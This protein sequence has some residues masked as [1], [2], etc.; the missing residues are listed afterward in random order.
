L[1]PILFNLHREYLTKKDPEVYGDFR[2]GREVIRTVKCEDDLVLLAKDGTV[3]RGMTDRVV[4]SGKMLWKENECRN[5][6]VMRISGQP[7]PIQITKNNR[8]MWNTSTIRVAR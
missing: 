4:G 1:S 8:R 2:I 6:K 5:T 7:S 3:I